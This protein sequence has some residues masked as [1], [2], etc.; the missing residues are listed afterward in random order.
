MRYNQS[1]DL[2]YEVAFKIAFYLCKNTVKLYM[3]Y[4]CHVQTRIRNYYLDMMDKLQNRVYVIRCA[5]WYHQYNLKNVKNTHGGVLILVKL[6]ACRLKHATLLKL[7]LLHGCFLGFLNCTNGT[8]SRNAS[9]ILRVSS[10][11]RP[12]GCVFRVLSNIYA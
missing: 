5:I 7:T 8:K 3:E 11:V 6:Q 10:F 2:F 4:S 12:L 9:H 1:L